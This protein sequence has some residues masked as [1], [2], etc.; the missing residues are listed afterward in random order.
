MDAVIQAEVST[1]EL[2][3]VMSYVEVVCYRGGTT[4][5]SAWVTVIIDQ[6][7]LIKGSLWANA[8]NEK[9]TST[10]DEISVKVGSNSHLPAF[11]PF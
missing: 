9:N 6:L 11:M 3:A 1:I 8:P 4:F 5:A 7:M 2:G 10:M